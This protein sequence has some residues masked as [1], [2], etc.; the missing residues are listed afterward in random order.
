MK[1]SELVIFNEE[2]VQILSIFDDL[3]LLEYIT[4]DFSPSRSIEW[5]SE[6]SV[7]DG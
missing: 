1:P 3:D 7:Y 6:F 5:T 2:L 4:L